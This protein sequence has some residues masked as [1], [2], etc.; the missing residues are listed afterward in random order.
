MLTSI[1][2]GSQR[3]AVN[4]CAARCL[5]WRPVADGEGAP[6]WARKEPMFKGAF[7]SS[8]PVEAICNV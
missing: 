6:P 5:A 8:G 4:P 7:G 3:G 2:L 1:L